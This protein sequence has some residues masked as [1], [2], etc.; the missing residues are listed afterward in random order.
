[1][2]GSSRL[3][4]P[5][6]ATLLGAKRRW[7]LR[8]GRSS[9]LSLGFWSP[10][11]SLALGRAHS[12]A[13]GS[14]KA[15][16]AQQALGELQ[17]PKHQTLCGCRRNW[18]SGAAEREILGAAGCSAKVRGRRKKGLAHPNQETS[19]NFLHRARAR[20]GAFLH[21]CSEEQKEAASQLIGALAQ[22]RRKWGE[23]PAAAPPDPP[24]SPR[25]FPRGKEPVNELH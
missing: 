20:S 17:A 19:E 5:G 13:P 21:S 7:L 14:G 18:D 8:L 16:R 10:K 15:E 24:L 23:S 11:C 22:A 25:G 12:T 3:R 2:L 4:V 9:A 1:M 6:T